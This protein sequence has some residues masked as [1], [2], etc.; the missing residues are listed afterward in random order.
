MLS[1]WKPVSR[2]EATNAR[3]DDCDVEAEG[4]MATTVEERHLLEGNI[5]DRFLGLALLRGLESES[6]VQGRDRRNLFRPLGKE[7]SRSD[8]ASELERE[9]EG[10]IKEGRDSEDPRMGVRSLRRRRATWS[11]I[12]VRATSFAL[13]SSPLSLYPPPP[14]LLPDGHPIPLPKTPFLSCDM[15]DH[16]E[17]ARFQALLDSAVEVY[18]KNTGVTLADPEDS[19]VIQLQCCHP[20]DDIA[21][22]LRRQAQAIHDFQQRDRIFK[23]IKTT[24]SMLSP[25]SSVADNVGLVREKVLMAGFT[26]L[27]V[28][29]DITPT[30]K[31]N[32]RYSWYPIEGMC[33]S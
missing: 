17:S 2:C 5:Y 11:R 8:L 28:F 12:C 18:E 27:T 25:I 6:G 13:R 23:S 3:A 32:K 30:R 22:L 9:S 24:V 31:D 29:T 14:V 16:P 4:S 15:T 10:K 20:L 21:T 33:R 19:L 1:V 7:L 26:S